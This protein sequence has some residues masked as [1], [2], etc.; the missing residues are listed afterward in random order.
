MWQRLKRLYH[1]LGSPKWFYDITNRWIPWLVVLVVLGA[2]VGL[3]L[4]LAFAPI[5]SEQANSYRIIYIHV[6][7]ALVAQS[8]YMM[9]AVA[10]AVYLIWKM[11][12]AA[13]VASVIAPVG[14][15]FCLI[16]LF[17]GAI[18][19]QPTWGTWWIWD[20][21][22]TSMLVLLFLYFGVIAI[23]QAMDS[24]ESGFK[25]AGIM[26]LV[27][28]VNIPI[29]KYSV[30]WWNTLHQPASLKVI[31]KSTVD[32]SML[33]PLLIMIITAYG[34]FALLVILRT[35]NKILWHERKSRWVKAIMGGI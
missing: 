3:T 11:K 35:R 20:A 12:M 15:S 19:G 7:A 31:E 34:F 27:G 21:R 30:N 18:W 16:A 26:S 22:L 14:A 24:E 5:H 4:G 23:T 32:W 28:L 2:A 6:P 25:A 29:I 17:T 9:M 1:R 33:I 13:W 10:G 8:A